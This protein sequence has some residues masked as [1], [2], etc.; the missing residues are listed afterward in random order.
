M[1]G[2][3]CQLAVPQARATPTV[4]SLASFLVLSGLLPEPEGNLQKAWSQ[5]WLAFTKLVFALWRDKDTIRMRGWNLGPRWDSG[6]LG[7]NNSRW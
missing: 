1:G 6:C 4:R 3:R 7:S 2:K 5:V